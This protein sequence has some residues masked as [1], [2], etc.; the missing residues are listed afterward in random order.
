MYSKFWFNQLHTPHKVS[1]IPDDL[2]FIHPDFQEI[3]LTIQVDS[4]GLLEA[5]QLLDII[6]SEL[7]TFEAFADDMKRLYNLDVVFRQLNIGD[8]GIA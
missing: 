4:D 8:G 5:Y 7:D 1:F 6:A 2:L 3:H